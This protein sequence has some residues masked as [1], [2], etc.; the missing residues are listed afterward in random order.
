MKSTLYLYPFICCKKIAVNT[1][2]QL[3]VI[4]IIA[5]F[6]SF[7]GNLHAQTPIQMAFWNFQ[8]AF[9]NYTE[10]PYSYNVGS[11]PSITFNP[12]AND[13]GGTEYTDVLNVLHHAHR[14]A[15]LNNPSAIIIGLA[16]EDF[17]KI[18]LRFDYKTSGITGLTLAYSL[19]NINYIDIGAAF[20][21]NT[22]NAWNTYTND[23]TG[24]TAIN[25]IQGVVYL[26]ISGFSGSGQIDI[27]NLEITG[28]AD[29]PKLFVSPTELNDLN[30]GLGSG[31]SDVQ[32]LVIEGIN[33]T[34]NIT[35]PFSGTHFGWSTDP[36]G[37][38]NTSN[39]TLAPSSGYA[40]ETYYVVLLAGKTAGVYT[41]T[42]NI[43]GGGVTTVSV[44][45]KG[46]VN[47]GACSDLFFSQYAYHINEGRF[48]EIYNPSPSSI[49][50][51]NYNLKIYQSGDFGDSTVISLPNFNLPAYS[52]IIFHNN[53]GAP[54]G[55]FQAVNL[56]GVYLSNLQFDGNDAVELRRGFISLDLIG[57][58]NAGDPGADG[59][60]NEG[61][62]TNGY[63]LIRKPFI[64]DGRINQGLFNDSLS[65][66]WAV[67]PIDRNNFYVSPTFNAGT[68]LCACNTAPVAESLSDI[69]TDATFTYPQLIAPCNYSSPTGQTSQAW[70]ESQPT[71]SLKMASFTMRDGALFTSSPPHSPDG[72]PTNMILLMAEITN[73]Q[74]LDS[75]AL[76]A[77]DNSGNPIYFL[78]AVAAGPT[79][80]FFADILATENS[81]V[82]FAI[83]ATFKNSTIDKQRII[84]KIAG[85]EVFDDVSSKFATFHAGNAATSTSA[86]DNV[87]E[88]ISTQL[89][90]VQQP[91]T[92]TALSIMR[93]PVVVKAADAC[94]NVDIDFNGQVTLDIVGATVPCSSLS[95]AVVNAVNGIATFPNLRPRVVSEMPNPALQLV[96]TSLPVLTPTPASN[97]FYVNA[98]GAAGVTVL[99]AEW[100]FNDF[101]VA[102]D[103]GIPINVSPARNL[104]ASGVAGFS[105]TP[106]FAQSNDWRTGTKY[107]AINFSTAGFKDIRISSKQRS[108]LSG[109]KD[110][111]LLLSTDNITFVDTIKTKYIVENNFTTGIIDRLILPSKAN[112]RDS[113]YLR[114]VKASNENVNSGPITIPAKSFIDDIIIEGISIGE[115]DPRENYHY[116]TAASGNYSNPCIWQFSPDNVQFDQAPVYPISSTSSI[117][118]RDNHIITHDLVPE[119]E[120]DQLTIANLGTFI[121]P[122]GKQ[123]KIADG[124]VA[125]ADL[126]LNGT[127]INESLSGQDITFNSGATW[128]FG[129][130]GNRTFINRGTFDPDNWHNAYHT[131]WNTTVF[132]NTQNWKLQRKIIGVNPVL[133]G[134]ITRYPNLVLEDSTGTLWDIPAQGRFFGSNT[135]L[136][137]GRL[138]I[139]GTGNGTVKAY[140]EISS[141][142]TLTINDSLIIRSGNILSNDGSTKGYGINFGGAGMRVD[143][144]LQNQF[145]ADGLLN[146]TLNNNPQTINGSGSISTGHLN[147]LGTSGTRNITYQMTGTNWITIFKNLNIASGYTFTND[148]ISK[149]YG[150]D[151]KGNISI[152]GSGNLNLTGGTSY[153][154]R[155]RLS[156]TVSQTISAN[157]TTPFI[158]LQDLEINN[159]LG[160][161]WDV[162]TQQNGVL[163]L[164][165]G[166]ITTNSTK[167]LTMGP[168]ATVAGS[169]GNNSYIKGMLKRQVNTTGKEYVFPIG[170]NE[171]FPSGTL[172]P[173]SYRPVSILPTIISTTETFSAEHKVLPSLNT[174]YLGSFVLGRRIDEYW[175]VNKETPG[176]VTARIKLNYVYSDDPADWHSGVPP[177]NMNVAI[178]KFYASSNAWYLAG[179]IDAGSSNVIESTP[180]FVM[181]RYWTDG[182]GELWTQPISQFS[183][184]GIIYGQNSILPVVMLNFNGTKSGNNH[185]LNWELANEKEVRTIFL[186]HSTNGTLFSTLTSLSNIKSKD[187]YLHMNPSAGMHYYRL[188]AIGTSGKITYSKT[189]TLSNGDDKTIITGLQQNPVQERANVQ[190]WSATGQ[191]VRATI[192]DAGG[193]NYRSF[194]SNLQRGSNSWPITLPLGFANGLYYLRVITDDGVTKTIPFMKDR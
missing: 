151:V 135:M 139:G 150:L 163:T 165:N 128:Q 152:T 66:Q 22:N 145:G 38:Y 164:T 68:H 118:I 158:T 180:P 2:R 81:S 43:S 117:L 138:D 189:I 175:N 144:A 159:V 23:L 106:G 60:K 93:P 192:T 188:K 58:V 116:R 90:Y 92:T 148:G 63:N 85:A 12:A 1:Y 53:D 50:L 28:T 147:T 107:W 124:P 46:T 7:G 115:V 77:A 36:A 108:E 91:S 13:V 161:N 8:D 173:T 20:N 141:T 70:W 62:S 143:G 69:V 190:I 83:K 71:W 105:A 4:A 75:V 178:G 45:F 179:E 183:P 78:S 3:S 19:D 48:I 126:M 194:T 95:G 49:T 142:N 41:N 130:S 114:W 125:G 184:F 44:T 89:L 102:S 30:Y 25:N 129:A 154:G 113:V 27:D 61:I 54:S 146:F 157:T 88:I 15:S 104:T 191:Q 40:S 97:G 73:Y 82:K 153:T 167:H 181:S 16:T 127:F 86:N 80:S 32:A 101:N 137:Q 56:S 193:R 187:S 47:S 31:P 111:I 37:P 119:V 35:I 18:K 121:L 122:T 169:P 42:L 134:T 172:A 166:I 87:I 79:V 29:I 112:D 185:L 33:L 59:W 96:A 168:N 67:Q 76:F 160:A 65:Y 72:K 14:A 123:L 155:L 5:A 57:N 174:T 6:L 162:I 39:I 133:S 84:F 94:G 24:T 171:L 11:V 21:T 132:N 74:N 170:G 186:E 10:I 176:S 17:Q 156:G 52:T 34:G 131:T 182:T 149:G 109:P 26:R 103:A 99:L 177:L 100:N 51:S 9:N 136:I 120:V 64:T 55:L 98:I 110:F 140:N